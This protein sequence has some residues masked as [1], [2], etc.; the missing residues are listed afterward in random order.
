MGGGSIVRKVSNL[1]GAAGID[2]HIIARR[3]NKAERH[4]DEVTGAAE[5]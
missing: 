3:N 4:E 5:S 2:V 1:A